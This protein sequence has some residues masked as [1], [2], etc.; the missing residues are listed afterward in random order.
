MDDRDPVLDVAIREIA[1]LLAAVYL[2]LRLE[3]GAQKGLDSPETQSAH[4]TGGG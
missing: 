4:V 2:R 3:S 1:A